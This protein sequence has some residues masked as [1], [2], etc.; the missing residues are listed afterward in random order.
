MNDSGHNI[1]I[2]N[3]HELYCRQLNEKFRTP[4]NPML[5]FLHEGLGSIQQWWDFPFDVSH[6]SGCPA[7]LYDRYGYGKSEALRESR[8]RNYLEEEALT[9]LPDVLRALAIDGPVIL[10]GHSDGG[11]IALIFAARFPQKVA[12]IITEAPH[13]MVEEI[14]LSGIR[15]AVSFYKSGGLKKMLTKY[16]G[17]KTDSMF[18]G[19][20]D[21]WLSFEHSDWNMLHLLPDIKAPVLAIQGEEDQYGTEAQID[22]IVNRVSGPAR[23]LMIPGCGHTPHIEAGELVAREMIDFILSIKKNLN[24]N[25]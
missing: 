23:K 4:E 14:S 12:G 24:K 19:W 5:V 6:N 2:A 16:H 8:R 9:A 18:F 3:G 17:L 15:E 1:V 20:A 22:S 21:T 7:L 13:V 25:L 11:S 10:V